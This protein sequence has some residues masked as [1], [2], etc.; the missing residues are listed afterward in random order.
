MKEKSKAQIL[1]DHFNNYSKEKQMEFCMIFTQNQSFD[2]FTQNDLCQLINEWCGN[3]PLSCVLLKNGSICAVTSKTRDNFVSV[4]VDTKF[5]H[6]I[7]SL[8][9]SFFQV[10]ID[11][12]GDEFNMLHFTKYDIENYLLLLP[13]L[14]VDRFLQKP[15]QN[16]YYI[17]TDEWMEMNKHSM[18]TS[19]RMK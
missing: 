18:F 16:K 2:F 10:H 8:A 6:E 11:T 7:K 19:Y 13:K 3:K 5:H 1:H 9:M 17:I 15:N 14:A 12:T 4:K